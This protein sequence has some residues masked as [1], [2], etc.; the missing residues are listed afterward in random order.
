VELS[1][2]EIDAVVGVFFEGDA[3][4]LAAAADAGLVEELLEERFDVG[5]GDVEAGADFFVGE[6]FEDGFEDEFFAWGESGGGGGRLGACGCDEGFDGAGVEGG[7]AAEDFVDGDDEIG[8]WTVLEEDA[9]GS[10][11]EDAEGVRVAEAGGDHEDAAGEVFFAG[12]LEEVDAGLFAEVEV[13]EDDVDVGGGEGLES[14][15]GGGEVACEFEGWVGFEETL[16]A[17]AEEAVIIDQQEADLLIG[18]LWHRAH[19][20]NRV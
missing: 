8:G 20:E 16:Q 3:D 6:T 15:V 5:L 13:E 10:E 19:P 17:F 18:G 14:G 1:G 2:V 11:L 12:L 4:E 9:G 7:F